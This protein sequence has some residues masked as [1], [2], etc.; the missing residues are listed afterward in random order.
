M[1]LDL[2]ELYVFFLYFEKGYLIYGIQKFSI[3]LSGPAAL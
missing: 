3:V 1:I 2:E